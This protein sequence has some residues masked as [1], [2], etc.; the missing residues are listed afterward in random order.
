MR[1]LERDPEARPHQLRRWP[2]SSTASGSASLAGS[3]TRHESAWC[4]GHRHVPRAATRRLATAGC[5][6][7]RR[8]R[9]AALPAGLAAAVAAMIFLIGGTV[10]AI[11]ARRWDSQAGQVAG[12]TSNPS[13]SADVGVVVPVASPTP[14]P[15]A[16]P[17]V[18]AA[19]QLHPS[20][21]RRP[22]GASRRSHRSSARH[23]RRPHVR[24]QDRLRGRQWPA[25]ARDPAETVAPSTR[26][27][28][29]DYDAAA[30]LWSPRMPQ[31]PPADT[32]TCS[33]RCHHA[34]V[35]HRLHIDR[36]SVAKRTAVVSIDIT[37]YRSSGPPRRWSDLGSGPDRRGLAAG[38]S[39]P[40]RG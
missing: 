31:Y 37:E 12:D 8:R 14:S 11:F 32:S 19:R 27:W 2:P 6:G 7:E 28:N 40:R 24:R 22:S 10:G 30:A 1:L 18:T 15:V 13:G 39:T 3:P 35:I 23:P 9:T 21:L 20:R 33:L 5:A 16:L 26:P 34:I 17:S 25:S 29:A 36:M 38:R 4:G